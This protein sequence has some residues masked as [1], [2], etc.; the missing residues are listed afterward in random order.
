M[1]VFDGSTQFDFVD[2]PVASGETSSFNI[3]AFSN[4]SK[5]WDGS[6]AMGQEYAKARNKGCTLWSMMN[7]DDA[8]AGQMFTPPRT[9]AHSDYL[10]LEDLTKWAYVTKT[11][12]SGPKCEMGNSKDMYGLE[13]ILR[14]K[15]ISIDKRDWKCVKITHGDSTADIDSQTYTNPRTGKIARR[16]LAAALEDMPGGPV[17]KTLQ[18][19]PWVWW[20]PDEHPGGLVL[21]SPNG[22]GVGFMLVQHKVELGNRRVRKI[23]A[24][25]AD[26]AANLLYTG[27]SK[28]RPK[29]RQLREWS[30]WKPC[31]DAVGLKGLVLSSLYLRAS[32]IYAMPFG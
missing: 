3:S 30:F 16:L 31:T 12:K 7:S 15:G 11:A 28:T 26:T 32:Y 14:A 2:S 18:P 23:E 19:Y 1:G 13:T 8:A 5:R 24:F 9:S 27:G 21:G 17:D 6:P 22:V 10:Q 29:M 4:H 20:R 25:L